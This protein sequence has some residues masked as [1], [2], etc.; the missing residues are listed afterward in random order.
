MGKAKPTPLHTLKLSAKLGVTLAEMVLHIGQYGN[1]T[2]DWSS[3]VD[4]A[5]ELLR[6]AKVRP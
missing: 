2:D 5:R 1:L 3:L 4:K 6:V